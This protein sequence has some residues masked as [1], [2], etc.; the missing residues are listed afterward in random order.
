MT[1]EDQ[2]G[3]ALESIDSRLYS[4]RVV[5]DGGMESANLVDTTQRIAEGL[6]AVAEG[7]TAVATAAFAVSKAID[8]VSAAMRDDR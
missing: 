7:I 4:P 5:D 8:K 3:D 1:T 6:F 2:I